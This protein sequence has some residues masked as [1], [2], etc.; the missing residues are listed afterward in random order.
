MQGRGGVKGRCILQGVRILRCSFDSGHEIIIFFFLVGGCSR[1][2][3]SWRK[4]LTSL[5]VSAT[6]TTTKTP[7]TSHLPVCRTP[8]LVYKP[9][10]GR[11]AKECINELAGR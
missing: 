4:V 10:G 7:A 9:T 8:S 11:V 1:Q 6:A 5:T 2:V 3:F